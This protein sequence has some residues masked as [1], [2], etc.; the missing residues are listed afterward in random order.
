MEPGCGRDERFGQYLES[1]DKPRAPRGIQDGTMRIGEVGRPPR[2]PS[3]RERF[4]LFD[5][6]LKGATG[7]RPGTH[8]AFTCDLNDPRGVGYEVVLGKGAT[9]GDSVPHAAQRCAD[10]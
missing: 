9:I 1:S 2:D 5:H 8:A 3:N 10:G 7:N 6:Y 4:G